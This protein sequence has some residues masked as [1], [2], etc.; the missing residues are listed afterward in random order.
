MSTA[1]KGGKKSLLVACI[2][3]SIAF[4][5]YG[6]MFVNRYG[7]GTTQNNLLRGVLTVLFAI[8]A[9]MNYVNYKRAKD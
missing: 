6:V 2:L 4:V 7:T 3:F 9:V 8:L 5:I 1:R